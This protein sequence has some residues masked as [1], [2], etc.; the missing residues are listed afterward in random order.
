MTFVHHKYVSLYI[1]RVYSVYSNIFFSHGNVLGKR[2]QIDGDPVGVE[3]VPEM[4]YRGS[5]EV[6]SRKTVGDPV[7]VGT[8]T[9][10]IPG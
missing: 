1:G 5:P 2:S 6:K 7:V 9:T 8:K 10:K 4:M 3:G